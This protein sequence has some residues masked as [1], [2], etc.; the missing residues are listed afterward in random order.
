MPTPAPPYIPSYGGRV[1]GFGR[2]G[3]GQHGCRGHRRK[4]YDTDILANYSVSTGHVPML[5]VHH[6]PKM[7]PLLINLIGRLDQPVA[8]WQTGIPWMPPL[9]TLPFPVL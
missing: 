7:V 8:P 3:P 1:G 5:L 4:S 2:P 9:R 6:G